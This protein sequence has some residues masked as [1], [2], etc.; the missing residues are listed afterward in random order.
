MGMMV[1]DLTRWLLSIL[2]ALTGAWYLAALAGCLVTRRGVWR[3]AV[4]AFAHL[5]MSAAMVAMF[6]TWGQHVPTITQVT[7]FTAAAAWFAGQVLLAEPSAGSTAGDLLETHTGGSVPGCV[8][9][10]D[11]RARVRELL[12][13]RA[14]S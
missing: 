3:P 10:G 7:V 5:L 11:T 14:G 1:G 12:D 2:F 4:G 6:W 13:A 8:T 9:P